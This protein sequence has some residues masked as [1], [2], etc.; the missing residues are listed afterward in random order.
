MC[1]MRSALP[2]IEGQSYVGIAMLAGAAAT[3]MAQWGLI[4]I[5]R[6]E[7]RDLIRWGALLALVGNLISAIAQDF[8][9]VVLGYAVMSRWAWASPGPVSW[10]ARR[11]RWMPA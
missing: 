7:P 11:W 6:L 3:L 2:P 5:F 8:Y 10:P 9:G 4:R 1:S